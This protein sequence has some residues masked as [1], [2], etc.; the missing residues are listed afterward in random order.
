MG[1]YGWGT[2][3][4]SGTVP[5][6]S[7]ARWRVSANTPA[8]I[9]TKWWGSTVSETTPVWAEQD[10]EFQQA[11]HEWTMKGKTTAPHVIEKKKRVSESMSHA[12]GKKKF[13]RKPHL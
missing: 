6:V 9:D 11:C 12:G 4:V 3:R 5:H 7:G 10:G 8:C 2:G 13:Q 1:I